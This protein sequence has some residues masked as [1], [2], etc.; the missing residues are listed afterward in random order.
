[1]QASQSEFRSLRRRA[2]APIERIE[3]EDGSWLDPQ[4]Q[5]LPAAST[6]TWKRGPF[7]LRV[8]PRLDTTRADRVLSEL[9]S[10]AE[11]S[12]IAD[13][14]T[15]T[16]FEAGALSLADDPL[17]MSAADWA[18]AVAVAFHRTF[19]CDNGILL[20]RGR[21]FVWDRYA[22]PPSALI[23][24][25]VR[26]KK[27]NGRLELRDY[28]SATAVLTKEQVRTLG[29]FRTDDGIAFWRETL[30]M[31]RQ[32]PLLALLCRLPGVTSGEEVGAA[33]LTAIPPS[34]RLL[35]DRLM[36]AGEPLTAPPASDAATPPNVI[37]ETKGEEAVIQFSDPI[38]GARTRHRIPLG[39]RAVH[40]RSMTSAPTPNSDADLRRGRPRQ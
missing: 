22:E 24:G 37:W 19:R 3:A 23:E 9:A 20:L 15:R 26:S 35:L 2:L 40:T 1:M 8:Q 14:F 4:R 36:L 18:R 29:R 33:S 21:K 28:A 6:R 34:Y 25:L 10:R 39:P 13:S 5:A 11:I 31:E 17:P 32:R 7:V 30:T 27:E 12:I 16:S 38:S